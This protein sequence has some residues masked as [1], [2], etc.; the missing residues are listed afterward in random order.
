MLAGTIVRCDGGAVTPYNRQALALQP[1]PAAATGARHAPIS[2]KRPVERQAQD[3]RS[4]GAVPRTSGTTTSMPL[5]DVTRLLQAF[6]WPELPSAKRRTAD[7]PTGAEGGAAK[8]ARQAPSQSRAI[9]LRPPAQ[10][11]PAIQITYAQPQNDLA[12][13]LQRTL[14][15]PL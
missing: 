3:G 9:M 12:D 2:R 13:R 7:E 14:R 10:Q 4:L 1:P 5:R 15:A 8:Q 11:P 6:M